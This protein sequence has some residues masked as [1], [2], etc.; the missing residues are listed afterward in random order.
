MKWYCRIPSLQQNSN[1]HL[2]LKDGCC[3]MD[4]VECCGYKSKLV[5]KQVSGYI[6]KN[7]PRPFNSCGALYALVDMLFKNVGLFRMHLAL[8]LRDNKCLVYTEKIQ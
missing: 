4:T 3:I 7:S 5:V 2:V 6:I 1:T 8:I